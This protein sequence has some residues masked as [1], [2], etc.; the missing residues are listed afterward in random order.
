MSWREERATRAI[1]SDREKFQKVKKCKNC[2]SNALLLL[3]LGNPSK[4]KVWKIGG[5]GVRT[6]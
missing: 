1:E 4:K 2:F 3:H 6:G 5:R